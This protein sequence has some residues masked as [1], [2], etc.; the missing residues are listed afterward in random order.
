LIAHAFHSVNYPILPEVKV[1]DAGSR[2]EIL[3]IRHHTLYTPRDFDISPFFAVIKPTI[4]SGFDYRRLP[5]GDDDGARPNE[6]R[7]A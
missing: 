6:E 1:A 7:L 5:W 3:H 4:E 2:A